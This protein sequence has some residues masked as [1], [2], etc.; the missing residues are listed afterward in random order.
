[1]VYNVEPTRLIE[2][3]A[4]E[5]KKLIGAPSWSA[6]VRTGNH[7]QRPPVN[8]DWWYVRAAA[9][10]RT[11]YLL[12]PI[13]VSKLRTKYGG[14]KNRGVR[15]EKFVK[16]SG[17]IIR[18]ILQ[19]LEKAE[20]VKQAQKGKHKGRIITPKG[21]SLL[22]TVT[23][24]ISGSKPKTQPKPVETKKEVLPA[25]KKAVVKKPEAPTAIVEVKKA[26]ETKVSEP[27]TK[28]KEIKEVTVKKEEKKDE[29]KQKSKQ[30][31]NKNTKTK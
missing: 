3:T 10:L 7:K 18:K 4:D 24:K 14:K 2:K 5:L 16:G 30:E 21:M 28:P 12:G 13:G 6:F 31:K 29:T 17:N 23:K 15:P 25:D 26:T 8:P 11:I 19:E 20:L 22:F 1:M 9:V 27:Q